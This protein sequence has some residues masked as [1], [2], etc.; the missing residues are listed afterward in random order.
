MQPLDELKT[1]YTIP[2]AWNDEGLTGSPSKCGR[3]PFRD[4]RKPSFSVFANGQRWK[5]HSTGKGGDVLSFLQLARNCSFSEALRIARNRS[6]LPRIPQWKAASPQQRISQ[7]T[8]TTSANTPQSAPTLPQVISDKWKEGLIHLQNDSHECDAID[9]ARNWP[10]GTTRTLCEHELIALPTNNGQRGVA[11]SVQ[12]PTKSGLALS[13]FHFRTH[14]KKWFFYPNA[15]QHNQSTPPL[16]FVMGHG[17]LTHAKLI[18]ITEGQWDCVAL[19]AWLGWLESDQSW[20]DR[21]TLFGIRGAHNWRKLLEYYT[22]PGSASI[23]L[24]PD[25]DKAGMTW[26]AEF[27]NELKKRSQKVSVC[28]PKDGDLTDQ[29]SSTDDKRALLRARPTL[30]VISHDAG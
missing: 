27:L 22:W 2:D 15:R 26:K 8:K 7:V 24:I 18:I 28:V 19:A 30:R 3:S 16:P 21:I 14:D 17:H 29:L 12:L 25:N 6:N 20:P 1:R 9:K 23:A 13:G 10:N 11:F 4:D 5:D